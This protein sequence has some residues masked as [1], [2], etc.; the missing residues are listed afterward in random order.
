MSKHR[1]KQPLHLTTARKLEEDIGATTAARLPALHVLSKKYSVSP[2]TMLKAIHVLRDKGVLKVTQGSRPVVAG[3]QE[4]SVDEDSS[5][6]KLFEDIKLKISEGHYRRGQRLPKIEYFTL[7]THVSRCAVCEAFELLRKQDLAHKKGNRWIV[8]PERRMAH[9]PVSMASALRLRPV[10]FVL[11]ASREGWV[12]YCENGH[13]RPFFLTLGSEL[14]RYGIAT[15]NATVERGDLYMADAAAPGDKAVKKIIDDLGDRYRGTLMLSN[16]YN[17]FPDLA[18][19]VQWLGTY[20]KPILWFDHDDSWPD[21]DRRSTGTRT[22]YRCCWNQT[23]AVRDAVTAL[24]DLGHRSI[25]VL[26]NVRYR[27]FPWPDDR[28]A[29]VR[30]FAAEHPLAPSIVTYRQEE[31]LWLHGAENQNTIAW[32]EARLSK[33]IEREHPSAP[34]EERESM[35]RNALLE[36]VPSLGS[37]VSPPKVTALVAVNQWLAHNYY[38]WLS[39]VGTRVPEDITLISFDNHLEFFLTPVSTMDFGFGD[40]GYSAAHVFIGD[41]PV[42]ADRRGNI[43]NVPKLLDRGS[44]ASPRKRR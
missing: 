41:M 14:D 22:F 42:K 10:V 16:Q 17:K 6:H 5:S 26:T 34:D 28:V 35:L 9:P 15:A 1:R 30:Q 2:V 3:R 23:Q 33:K 13:L 11:S 36:T 32:H 31:L 40:L 38:Y 24:C 21:I 4:G 29:L 39:R 18:Q 12:R 25:G 44:L 20:G 27:H 19:W 8:G 43:R 37:L 7:S